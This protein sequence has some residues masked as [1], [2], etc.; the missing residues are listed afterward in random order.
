MLLLVY[1]RLYIIYTLAGFLLFDLDQSSICID[2][3][4]IEKPTMECVPIPQKIYPIT[5][6]LEKPEDVEHHFPQAFLL[7]QIAQ[8]NNIYQQDLLTRIEERY[9][10]Q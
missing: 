6:R 5:E 4:K 1:Y 3:Q 10:T 8:N 9:S 7:L 2:I